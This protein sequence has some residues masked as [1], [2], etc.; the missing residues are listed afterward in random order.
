MLGQMQD[1]PLLV[2]KMLEHAELNH[3]D[4][5]LVSMLPEGGQIRTNYREV[6]KRSRQLSQAIT[7]LGVKFGDR[8]GT[9]AWNTHRHMECW[10][11]ISGIGAVAHTIN[12]RL[13]AE[14]I[15]YIMNHAEDKILFLD[16]TFV[17]LIE[18]L[19]E[20][21]TTVEHFI[22]MVGADHMPETGLKN[23]HCYETLLAAE[24]GVLN[25]PEFDENTACGL[26]YT[27][28]TT[29]H[30]KGVLYSHR[31]N[32]LHTMAAICGDTLGIGALSVILPVVPMFHANAWGIPYAAAATGAKIVFNG[33]HHEPD[34]LHKLM[35]EEGVTVTAAV[36][37]IW[38]GM[39]KYLETTGKDCG[40]LE[41][42]TIGGSAAPRTMIQA[43]QEKYGV[44]VNHAWGMT[45]LSPLGSLGSYNAAVETLS[46]AEKLDV[47]CKQ[48]RAVLGV[49]MCVKDT[50]GNILPRDGKSSGHLMVRGPWTVE[51]Y[52]RHEGGDILDQDGWFDTGDV[53]CID[54]YGYM[55][56]TDRSKDVIKSGG[57]WISSID[58]E[59]AA[60]SHPAIS[61]AAV[62]G[63]AHPKWDERPLLVVTLEDGES[64][65][66]DDVHAHLSDHVAK[67]WLPDDMIVVD[68][69]P[70]TATGKISKKD[71]RD[72][73]KDYSL[74]TV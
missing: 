35:M 54:E 41:R 65:S 58:L 11:G 2:T 42:V 10:Y 45:E 7:R 72:R 53:A 39:L 67:W 57:E 22:I 25:W 24:D 13:F 73:F 68:D 37:T 51:S 34:V 48:G 1:W 56:I 29:G 14:Q 3:A 8:V 9:L 28:G 16:V 38:M 49:E 64:V 50:D 31:S 59:N 69:I 21:L 43:F 32:Y 52:F 27:S 70:H 71:L 4:R 62:I 66:L 12:P 47:K 20:H 30:P 6:A 40:R 15:V 44:S 36:P 19:A 23:V 17:P 46:D 18:K 61:E 33:P 26:C 63:I 60:I 5:E 74:P 55:Q